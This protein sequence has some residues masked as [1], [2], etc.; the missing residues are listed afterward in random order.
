[1]NEQ[2]SATLSRK[3]TETNIEVSLVLDGQGESDIST[4][5]GFLDHMLTAF[6]RHSRVDL[7]ITC[8]GDLD[9]DDHHTVEDCA[10]A[11]GSAFDRALGERRGIVRF[12]SAFAPLDEALARVVMDLSGRPSSVV[13]LGLRRERIGDVASEN[14]DH[15]FVSFAS[16]CRCALHID[17]LRGKNDHHRIESAFKA[18]ALAVRQAVAIDVVRPDTVPSTKGVL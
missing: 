16:A 15:F 12:G 4:G 3:T 10:L 1:M 18:F 6:T 14:L 8:V 13:D 7:T 5:L 9:V 11:L 2:R 17:V